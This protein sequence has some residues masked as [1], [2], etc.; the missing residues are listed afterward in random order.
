MVPCSATGTA[1]NCNPIEQTGC[2]QGAA[3][4]LVKD[5]ITGCVCLVGTS[6]E[7]GA[8]TK[9]YECAPGLV[10]AGTTAPGVCTKICDPAN[11]QCPTGTSCL[12]ITAFQ[13]YGYCK[14]K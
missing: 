9:T 12:E 8:C 5:V 3:C 11:D 14:T 2:S 13:G 10:C 4:S 6:P 1:A 7:G